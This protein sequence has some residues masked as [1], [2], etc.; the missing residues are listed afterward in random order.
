MDDDGAADV[1]AVDRLDG[2]AYWEV[3]LS[4]SKN[5]LNA[6]M[7]QALT[8]LFERAAADRDVKALAL[9]GEDRHF[10]FGASVP[11]HLPEAVS[12]MLP[13]F[14]SLFR[15]MAASSV[16]CLAAIRGQCLGGGLELAMFCHRVFAA[17]DSRLGQPE[18]TLGVFAPVASLLL[19]QRIGRANAEDLCL[20]GRVV[21]AAEAL[22]MGLVDVVTDEPE[23][24]ARDYFREYLSPKSASSLRFAVKACRHRV[25]RLL[26]EDLPA[27]ERLYLD[28]SDGLMATSDAAEG[29]RAFVDKRPPAWRNR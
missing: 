27:I 7:V 23:R 14:H 29:I 28:G 15:T 11:E 19:E 24:S 1:L 26:V 9:L 20:T 12:E 8:R 5:V 3:R 13:R 21:G 16:P 18:I 22:R 10:S 6:P 17:P 25:E 2:G 4:G